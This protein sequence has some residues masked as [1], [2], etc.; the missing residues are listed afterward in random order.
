MME[1]SIGVG[2]F[3]FC[4][5]YLYFGFLPSFCLGY[6]RS[7]RI[8]NKA[9]VGVHVMMNEFAVGGQ[10]LLQACRRKIMSYSSELQ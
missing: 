1:D 8:Y 9:T 7:T 3:I 5:T 6:G 10:T 2:R 4:G